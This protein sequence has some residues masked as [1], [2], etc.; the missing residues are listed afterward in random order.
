MDRAIVRTL[1]QTH[2]GINP[3][4]GFG[5]HREVVVGDLRLS[6]PSCFYQ[7]ADTRS[8]EYAQ[9]KTTASSMART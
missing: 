1:S 3:T 4:Y 6:H 8:R 7:N 5:S 9:A 2:R